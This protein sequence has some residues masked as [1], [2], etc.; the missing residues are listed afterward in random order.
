M[1]PRPVRTTSRTFCA[2]FLHAL[3]ALDFKSCSS[4]TRGPLRTMDAASTAA[5]Q[6]QLQRLEAHAADSSRVGSTPLRQLLALG[7]LITMIS[8]NMLDENQTVGA[9][10]KMMLLIKQMKVIVEDTGGA[11]GASALD[12]LGHLKDLGSWGL[13]TRAHSLRAT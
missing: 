2:R 3:L 7:K 6:Q 13:C 4:D 10:E 12:L 5:A 9:K 8:T 1:P 11:D